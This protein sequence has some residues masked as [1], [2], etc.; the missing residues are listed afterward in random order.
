[1]NQ[2]GNQFENAEGPLQDWAK[3]GLDLV[4][5]HDYILPEGEPWISPVIYALIAL[6]QASMAGARIQCW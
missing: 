6:L 2:G 3:Q 4:A 1:M 5:L